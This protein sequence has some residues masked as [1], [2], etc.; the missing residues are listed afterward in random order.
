MTI[1][2]KF[3][4]LSCL[5]CQSIASLFLFS[6]TSVLYLQPKIT[7][8][9]NHVKIMEHV[10]VIPKTTLVRVLQITLEK[11]VKVC[12]LGSF[13]EKNNFTKPFLCQIINLAA[14]TLY[15]QVLD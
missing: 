2:W 13:L 9:T 4:I 15:F 12:C 6:V 7:A 3:Q 5:F 1:A 14:F 10:I 11:A 8:F